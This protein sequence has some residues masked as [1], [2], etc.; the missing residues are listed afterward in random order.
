M[1]RDDKKTGKQPYTKPALR[2]IELVTEEVLG[3]GCKSEGAVGPGEAGA[4]LVTGCA[5]LAS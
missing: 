4:C 2:P 3:N 1:E 5:D